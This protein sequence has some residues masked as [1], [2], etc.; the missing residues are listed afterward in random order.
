MIIIKSSEEIKK[1]RKSCQIVAEALEA[2]KTYI[3]EGLTTK[4]VESFIEK[5]IIKRGGIS[6]FKGYRGY[7]SSVCVSV[8][9][10][11][12]HGI[13]SVRQVI[14]EGDIVS[15]DVGVILDGFYG[16]GAYTYAV[17]K[18]S[19]EA[20][21]LLKVTEESLYIGIEQAVVGKRIGD[22]S[23]A[24]QS[25]VELNGFSVVRAF[26]GHGI[27]RS[28]HEDPQVPNFGTEGTGPRL[29][30]GMTLAIEPM[31]NAGTFDVRVLEDGWTVVTKDGSLS[32][33][34]EHTIAITEDRPEIL[35]KI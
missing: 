33:H 22:I 31:V 11:V 16:D 34:F 8:N 20:E 14:K 35:T 18:I 10:Q 29:K 24:I 32:A 12:V 5:I 30:A 23:K 7:P 3:K 21:R 9:E 28:L 6:A 17:G 19:N 1:I 26:V 2:L 4:D 13:P 25:H 15:V 27:G